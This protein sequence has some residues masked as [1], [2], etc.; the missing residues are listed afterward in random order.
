MVATP[1]PGPLIGR[2]A[3]WAAVGDAVD[4]LASGTG[5]VL[6]VTG[7]P[8]IGKSRLLTETA[9]ESRR[10]GHLVLAGSGT[11]F[12]RELP[13]GMWIDV[14]DGAAAACPDRAGVADPELAALCAEVASPGRDLA[15]PG[16][17]FRRHRRVRAALQRAAARRPVVL[18]LDD[19]Q[20]ADAA[21]VELIV[22]L[23]RRPTAG[24]VLLVAAWRD[25]QGCPSVTG[26]FEGAL[27]A[28]TG[29][30]L[31]LGPLSR[32]EADE[33]LGAPAGAQLFADSGGNPFYLQQLHRAGGG[34]RRS[35]DVPARIRAS[36]DAE[37]AMLTPGARRLATGAA[38]VG[39]PVPLD[40]AAAAAGL[41]RTAALAAL[42]ELVAA[43]LL[44]TDG[45]AHRFRHP[46]VRRSVYLGIPDG[47][48][49]AAH[50]GAAEALARTAPA[51]PAHAHHVERSAATGDEQAAAV[52][53]AAAGRVTGTAPAT[54]LRW[55]EA[56]LRLQPGRAATTAAVGATLM[57]VGRLA[58]GRDRLVEALA[59]L[60]AAE[61]E[62]RTRLVAA[63]AAADVLLGRHDAAHDRLVHALH[64]L[65]PGAAEPVA[66]LRVELAATAIH[67]AD[68]AAA[69]AHAR[70]ALAAAETA[71]RTA[72]AA[73]AAALVHFAV[74][75]TGATDPAATAARERAIE[76]VG[77]CT[78]AE[79]ATRPETALHLGYAEFFAEHPAEAARHF[80]RGLAVC[81]AAGQGQYLIPLGAGL[82]YALEAVGEL[83]AAAEAADAALESARLG[84]VATVTGWAAAGRAWV[85]AAAGELDLA[86]EL[87][88]E[89][90]GL[91]DTRDP[92]VIRSAIQAHLGVVRQEAAD[93]D[94]CVTA[95]HAAG[96]PGF[97]A[98]AA[99]R[100]PLWYEVLTRAELARGRAGAARR[101][102]RCAE[103]AD[104]GGVRP[105]SA[106]RVLHAGAAVLLADGDAAGA[107]ERALA[108]AALAESR[109]ARV[110]AGRARTTAGCALAAAGDVTGAVAHLSAAEAGL[111][112]SG[113]RRLR[114]RAAAELRR[115]GIRVAA[116]A[117]TGG[118]CGRLPAGL[119]DRERDV[120]ELVASGR[121]NRE[122]ARALYLSEKT[123]E[124]H[125]TQIY[126]RLGIRSRAALA[127]AVA[128]SADVA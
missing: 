47:S 123:V 13:F 70:R 22:H 80:R 115:L 35:P 111:A 20:W 62:S 61:C 49:I 56:A 90:D 41:G 2:R 7:E 9:T 33:L 5:A 48:R 24:P 79:L 3:E 64:A 83:P 92:G 27:R 110:E 108:A 85:A 17:R 81:R 57:A 112:A 128:R 118:P 25:G 40:L 23:V 72:T 125:L 88:D 100:R 102:W 87:A 65:P 59:L 34:G 89:A 122:V 117:T 18:L 114:D 116:R 44:R 32:A 84:G 1:G 8:G 58:D 73:S 99:E 42:D 97:T 16:E 107:A 30:A 21:S 54:A 12:E 104:P 119:T 95:L 39:D 94:R 127:A 77:R 36:I 37:L 67:R 50:T 43:D 38:V 19:V 101:W 10:R 52:L 75:T 91:V 26:A 124:G 78:D 55:Y 69:A 14:L 31:A 60:P 53:A 120:A 106:A 82:A 113:A 74:A 126:A 29:R 6:C 4:R 71:G 76:L 63:A 93:P 121:T 103:Q 46:I 96:A 51:S 68:Y 86:V 105:L 11:E 98:F 109:G 28:G 45:A 66:A 15:P